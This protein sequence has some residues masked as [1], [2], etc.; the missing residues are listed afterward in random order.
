[1]KVGDLVYAKHP[2][3][4]GCWKPGIIVDKQKMYKVGYRYQVLFP[5]IGLNWIKFSDN[6]ILFE[7]WIGEK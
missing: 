7:D 2:R 4:I 1:V 3:M 5:V 6:L